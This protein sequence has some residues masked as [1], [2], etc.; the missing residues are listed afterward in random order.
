MEI[1]N[2]LREARQAT[3]ISRSRLAVKA[4]LNKDSLARMDEPDWNPKAGTIKALQQA[5]RDMEAK[6]QRARESPA[7]EAGQ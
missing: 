2:Q 6:M 3:G 7:A 1:L 5:F 4:G